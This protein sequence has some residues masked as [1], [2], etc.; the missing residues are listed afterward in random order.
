MSAQPFGSVTNDSLVS[1]TAE[2]NGD[3]VF[4][5]AELEA[6]SNT[7]VRRLA[8]NAD[9]DEIHGKSPRFQ[10]HAYFRVQRSLTE[11]SE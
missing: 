1:E 3:P 10:I 5:K 9:T 4:T 6:M 8:A 2:A 11:Y 7:M